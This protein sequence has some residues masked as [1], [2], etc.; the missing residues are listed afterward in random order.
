M[1]IAW[2][3]VSI[4]VGFFAAT[5]RG[6]SGVTWFF[7]SCLISPIL[8]LIFLLAMGKSSSSVI[9]ESL[10]PMSVQDFIDGINHIQVLSAD[11]TC[12][13]GKIDQAKKEFWE[14]FQKRTIHESTQ[15]FISGIRPLL[16]NGSISQSDMDKIL[17]KLNSRY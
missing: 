2:I 9:D 17:E 1:L 4:A 13:S 3:I 12:D 16:E 7:I 14:S 15:N 10:P 8:A 11:L 5:S 6:K